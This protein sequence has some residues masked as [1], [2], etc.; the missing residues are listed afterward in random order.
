MIDLRILR[1]NPDLLRASQR[2]RGASESAVDT[3]IKADEDNRAA[4][5]A[6]EV[7]RAEQKTLGKEVAKAKGDE[8]AALLV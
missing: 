7:L 4:L 5:H 8:K 6:F 3:L 1:E 2:T